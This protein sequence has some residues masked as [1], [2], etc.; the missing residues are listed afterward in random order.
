MAAG[1]WPAKAR[2][3]ARS[4]IR[5]VHSLNSQ[6]M[7]PSKLSAAE[8]SPYPRC[9]VHC[10]TTLLRKAQ[11]QAIG[12]QVGDDLFEILAPAT[13]AEVD[14]AF[15][16]TSR[17]RRSASGLMYGALKCCLDGGVQRDQVL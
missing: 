17:L 10:D 12:L 11:R 7:V 15:A 13:A 14:S 6:P 16:E 2:R 3:M 5:G 4:M 1:V 9:D 8:T